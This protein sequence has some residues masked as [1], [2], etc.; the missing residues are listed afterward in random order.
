MASIFT[1]KN[2]EILID[3]EDLDF[4]SQFTWCLGK[5]GYPQ[6]YIPGSKKALGKSRFV[7]LHNLLRGAPKGFDVAHVNENKQDARQKNLEVQTHTENERKKTRP[8]NV[9]IRKVG[10]RFWAR[11]RLRESGNSKQKEVFLGTYP[12]FDLALLARIIG[13]IRYWG[14]PTQQMP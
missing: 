13:E 5:T 8:S 11:I 12:T 4:V 2:E 14:E 6:A 9:G 10:K 1:N 7:R 3:D